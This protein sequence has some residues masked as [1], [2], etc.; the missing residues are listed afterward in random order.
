MIG[1]GRT[2]CL[3]AW[4]ASTCTVTRACRSAVFVCFFFFTC[5]EQFEGNC[6]S[7]DLFGL[8]GGRSF[9]RTSTLRLMG[10]MCM[11]FI[12]QEFL[13]Y[14]CVCVCARASLS[15]SLSLSLGICLQFLTEFIH[16]KTLHNYVNIIIFLLLHILHTESH[17]MP[18]WGERQK[19]YYASIFD[20]AFR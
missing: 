19:R 2:C 13:N 12:N 16:Q 9:Q 4:S 10:C 20:V 3:S 6:T 7:V 18:A 14:V 11:T 15:L 17:P 8:A 5:T 1:G